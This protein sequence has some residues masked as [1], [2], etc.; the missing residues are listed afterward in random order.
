MKKQKKIVID[1]SSGIVL[2]VVAVLA[3]AVTIG[4]VIS[5]TSYY[6]SAAKSKE[7]LEELAKLKKEFAEQIEYDHDTSD[8]GND[9]NVVSDADVS[10]DT[11]TQNNATQDN[12]EQSGEK[13]DIFSQYKD[14]IGWLTIEGTDMDYP[15][16]QTE[17]ENGEYYL[18]RDFE[19]NDDINGTPFLDIRCDI[20]NPKSNLLIH[21]HN[22]KSGYMFAELLEYKEESHY[23]EH[24]VICFETAGGKSEYL[25]FAAGL[26]QV[27]YQGEE[28]FRYYDFTEYKTEEEFNYFV[29]NVRNLSY[30]N[31]D[32]D[33]RYGDTLLTL[34]TCDRS[35]EDGRFFVVAKK[36]KEVENE[37]FSK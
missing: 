10:G 5:L 8:T 11:T 29:E 26:T 28:A 18:Y 4:C 34:S 23:K 36:I 9:G 27:A 14:I 6:S 22:M 2:I 17:K 24:P 12:N 16:M 13:T 30:Y 7:K 3:L 1:K 25:I 32:T 20:S 19:G 21:G 37:T 31:I 33:V 15:V 35:I